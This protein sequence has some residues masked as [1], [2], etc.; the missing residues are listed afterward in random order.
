L[1]EEMLRDRAPNWPITG[2]VLVAF[3]DTLKKID[4][5]VM[6]VE[7]ESSGVAARLLLN[8]FLHGARHFR[9]LTST[10]CRGRTTKHTRQ[11][12]ADNAIY[13]TLQLRNPSFMQLRQI[14]I[15]MLISHSYLSVAIAKQIKFF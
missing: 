14:I 13:F 4:R 12:A 1:A 15:K 9:S 7:T 6:A 5:K 8:L 2:Q 11:L 10:K 3:K